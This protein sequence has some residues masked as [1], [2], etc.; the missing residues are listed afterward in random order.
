MNLKFESIF[1]LKNT[2]EL[3]LNVLGYLTLRE[4]RESLASGR[5]PS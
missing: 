1:G 5:I 3:I 4:S 2:A